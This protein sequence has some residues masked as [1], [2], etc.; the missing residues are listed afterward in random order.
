MAENG[1][2]EF[3]IVLV[4]GVWSDGSAWAQVIAP[5]LMKGYEVQAA[6]MH[7]REFAEDVAV[8]EQVIARQTRPVVLVGHS[9]GGAVI[10]AAGNHSNVAKLVY[11]AAFAPE[12]GE[13]FGALLGMHPMAAQVEI[14][15][16]ADGLV[17]ATAEM[18]HDAIAQDVEIAALRVAAA[19]QNPYA[20]KLFA[21]TLEPPAWKTK[22]SWYLQTTEDRILNPKTQSV[23]AERIGAKTQEV[24]SGH[25]VIVSHP[26]AVVR[27][28]EA[29]ARA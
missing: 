21:A 22:S 27:I 3:S 1:K 10:T 28:I 25:L 9:Y 2:N 15:P 16:D 19:A 13:P 26:E 7:L 17:W 14:T 11:L 12:A 6:Q 18:L 4:H 23:L 8:V 20:A 29:A 24:A 5:L